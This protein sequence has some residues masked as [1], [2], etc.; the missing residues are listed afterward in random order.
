MKNFYI[1]LIGFLLTT[2]SNAQYIEIQNLQ[3]DGES[4]S[5][6]TLD[7]P[8]TGSVDLIF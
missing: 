1:L 2:V 5:G 8:E 7:L 6:Q 3:V 4:I